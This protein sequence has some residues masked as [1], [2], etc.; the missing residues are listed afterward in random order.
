MERV[1]ESP[2]KKH[3]NFCM[4]PVIRRLISLSLELLAYKTLAPSIRSPVVN[5]RSLEAEVQPTLEPSTET[6]VI[7]LMR[8]PRERRGFDRCVWCVRYVR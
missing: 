4:N 8:Q 2:G 1:L 7:S 3:F 5:V 6:S